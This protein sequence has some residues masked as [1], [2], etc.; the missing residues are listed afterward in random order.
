MVLERIDGGG[1]RLGRLVECGQPRR[2]AA[3][4][5]LGGGDA[6]RTRLRAADREPRVGHRAVLQPIGRERHRDG[7]IAGAAAE[8]DE[9]GMRARRQQRQFRGD[10]QLVLGERGRHQAEMKVRRRDPPRAARAA[11]D[12]DAVERRRRAAPLGGRIGVGEAAAERSAR[13]DRMVGDVAHHL[14]QER[15]GDA[16][17]GRPLE[18][19]MAHAGADAHD[20][21]P[22][23]DPRQLGDAVDVDEMGR[24]REA[25][26]H[27]GHEALPAGENAAVV[28]RQ[29]GQERHRLIDGARGVIAEGGGFHG[30]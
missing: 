7:E 3:Q 5:L 23:R 13:A 26:R 16:W 10:D 11:G 28:R 6:A 27:R 9:A 30:A 19:G 29:L 14:A 18:R 24:P 4:R 15:P 2:A 1:R 22:D 8:F 17:N 12:D 21:V 25:K 20:A